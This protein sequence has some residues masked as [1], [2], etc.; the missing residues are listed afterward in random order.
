MIEY[1]IRIGGYVWKGENTEEEQ[2]LR[3]LAGAKRLVKRME[4][5]DKT[6]DVPNP[7][8]RVIVCREVG[9]WK[10]ARDGQA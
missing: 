7:P 9:P 3:S 1:A 8:K 5:A 2:L 4:E 10:E 6:Y